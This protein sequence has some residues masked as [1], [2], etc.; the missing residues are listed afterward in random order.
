MKNFISVDELKEN[1]KDIV[2]LDIRLD[3]HDPE[4][5]QK[6][7]NEG[8][9][10]GSFFIDLNSDLAGK[11]K[12]HGGSRP[13]PEINEFIK[14][15]EKLGITKNSSIVVYDEEIVAAAR[16]F[17]MF[18]YIG[19]EDIKIL[20]G[21]YKEWIKKDGSV[22]EEKSLF[23]KNSNYSFEIQKDIYVDID[24]V[25][26]AIEDKDISLVE[27]RSYERYLG[28]NEPFYSKPGHIPT[29]LSIDSKSLLNEDGKV[30]SVEELKEI[31]KRLENYKDVIFSCGSAVNASLDY[32][33]YSE[34]FSNGKVYI[35][36]YSDWISYPENPIEI[37]DEN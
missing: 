7:Y 27:S 21:G 33:I 36:S 22:T 1:L 31:F 23:P 10:K 29:A 30:K 32:A 8:H 12:T 2:V 25:K 11:K 26:E 24:K 20:D 9:I 34:F 5:G 14:K 28:L 19:H 3:L 17:W 15:I 35:G 4:Y 6:V 16:A 37:K 13:L 18:K